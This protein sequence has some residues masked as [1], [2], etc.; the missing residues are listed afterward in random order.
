[1]A[2]AGSMVAAVAVGGRRASRTWSSAS[3]SRASSRPP[4]SSPGMPLSAT[5]S[6]IGDGLKTDIR[7]ANRLGARSVLMLT[8]VT[9]QADLDAAPATP[10]PTRV[11]HDATDGFARVLEELSRTG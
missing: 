2:G 3:P 5:R 4:R 10:D 9:T 6:S 8:G 11:A 7:A 1:M